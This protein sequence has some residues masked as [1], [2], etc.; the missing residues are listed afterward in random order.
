M[1]RRTQG[2]RLSCLQCVAALAARRFVAAALVAACVEVK[3]GRSAGGGGAGGGGD[4]DRDGG[5]GG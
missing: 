2:L 4:G 1:R 5:G 3:E